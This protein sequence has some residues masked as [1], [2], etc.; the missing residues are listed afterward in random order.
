[1]FKPLSVGS[2]GMGAIQVGRILAGAAGASQYHT[3][4]APD[5]QHELEV[6]QDRVCASRIIVC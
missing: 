2:C 6:V 1:M 5:L 4:T 3:V